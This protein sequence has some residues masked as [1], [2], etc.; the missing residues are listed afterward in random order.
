MIINIQKNIIRYQ[1]KT[2]NL[3]DY[4]AF[5]LSKYPD[6]C[7]KLFIKLIRYARG[8][9]LAT[10]DWLTIFEIAAETGIEYKFENTL[11]TTKCN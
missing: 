2:F 10:Y 11:N 3:D 9:K 1:K 4:R 7:S 6:L 5:L 8:K